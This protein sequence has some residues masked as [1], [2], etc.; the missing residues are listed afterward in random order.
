M[1]TAP[2]QTTFL[3]EPPAAVAGMIA[4]SGYR[5]IESD[6]LETAAG[7]APGLG[8]CMGTAFGRC[9]IPAATGDVSAHFRGFACLP[10]IVE[11]RA[12]DANIWR[13]KDAVAIMRRGQIWVPVA[14]TIGDDVPVYIVHSGADAGKIQPAAGAGPDAT[15]AAGVRCL[16][17]AAGGGIALVS[18]N[19]P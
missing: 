12:G 8:V 7:V 17:G 9:K 10:G 14:I 11:P 3:F 15:L 6:L 5:H 2:I 13:Q 4:D 18:I 16:K 19:L 1:A